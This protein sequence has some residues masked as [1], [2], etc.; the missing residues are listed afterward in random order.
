MTDTFELGKTIKCHKIEFNICPDLWIDASFILSK[1]KDKEF[2]EIKF[3][4]KSGT[5]LNNQVESLPLNGGLY[6]FIVKATSLPDTASYLLY[7]GRAKKTTT[8]NLKIRCKKY[9]TNYKNEKERPKISQMIHGYGKFLYL[10]YIDL[11]DNND[12]ISELEEK[13]INNLIPP[14]NDF[15]PDKS[16]RDAVKAFS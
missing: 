16:I 8:H 2:K 5:K 9:F 6:F 12:L 1:L 10:K 7:I 13:L 11:G 15:I 14:F 4:N 3:L